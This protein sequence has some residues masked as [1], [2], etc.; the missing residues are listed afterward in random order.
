MAIFRVSVD[1]RGRIV[2]PKEVREA[3]G[4]ASGDEVIIKVE[5]NKAILEKAEDPFEKLQELLGDLAF[6]RKLRKIA[7]EEGLRQA[8]KKGVG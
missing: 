8:S 7:E 3:I 1:E 2:I 5:N 6:S 4:I